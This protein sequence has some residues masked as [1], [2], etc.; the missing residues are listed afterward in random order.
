M[1]LRPRV[2][3]YAS[4]TKQYNSFMKGIRA[5]ASSIWVVNMVHAYLVAPSD[6]FFDGE[7][8]FDIEYN[9]SKL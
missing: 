7:Y 4:D 3:K 9:G 1:Q 8:F 6:D 2:I 5:V